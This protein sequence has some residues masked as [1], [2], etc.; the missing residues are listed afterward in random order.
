MWVGEREGSERRG[1]S[2]ALEE[3]LLH[4]EPAPSKA[5]QQAAHWLATRGAVPKQ[6]TPRQNARHPA[7]KTTERR[8]Q[9]RSRPLNQS[10]PARDRCLHPA[11]ACD[12]C[13]STVYFVLCAMHCALSIGL[14]V[15]PEPEHSPA[16][17]ASYH[18]SSIVG[19]QATLHITA[20]WPA[21]AR[22]DGSA[23]IIPPSFPAPRAA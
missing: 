19:R 18:E 11:V 15:W 23:I 8:R 9:A 2:D 7:Q 20:S 16:A 22:I 13:P 5:T 6:T 4:V 17:C 21:R 10:P 14:P 12:D 3:L 1:S